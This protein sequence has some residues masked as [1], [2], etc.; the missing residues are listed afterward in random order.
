MRSRAS[1][2]AAAAIVTGVT[3]VSGAEPPTGQPGLRQPDFAS[4]TIATT[5]LGHGVYVLSGA[6]VNSTVVVANDGVIVVDDEWTPV[7]EK[8]KTAVDKINNSAR[9]FVVNTHFH[10]DHSGG[11]AVFAQGGATLIAHD[12]VPKRLL[13]G[14]RS[15]SGSQIPPAPAIALPVITY[16]EAMT[17]HLNGATAEITHT[18]AS[19]TDGDSFVYFPEANVLAT[20]DL[21]NAFSYESP[22]PPHGGTWD[23][24][25][26]AEAAMLARIN[27]TTKVVPG[28]GPVTDK[29][30][31]A[32]FH[33]L[34]VAG[35]ARIAAL[36]A[37]G[38][39]EQEIVAAKPI[40][41]LT[42]PIKR[43]LKNDDTLVAGLYRELKKNP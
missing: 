10:N 25:I 33:A 23:G 18:N 12:G 13:E 37:Q 28:H 20:G 42:A 24:L 3:A 14:Y 6:N 17:I 22:N 4:A 27:D 2:L 40:A 39:T 31:L 29:K 16:S 35:R 26:A 19:H 9:R 43:E 1:V 38:K 32:A 11:N 21:F 36:I 34:L 30:D 15:A 5:D 7:A 8:L 41:D